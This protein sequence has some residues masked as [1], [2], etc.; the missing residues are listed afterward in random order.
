MVMI[1]DGSVR[2]SGIAAGGLTLISTTTE[3]KDVEE[4]TDVSLPVDPEDDP[5]QDLSP[6]DAVILLAS[7]LAAG[8]LFSF[9]FKLFMSGQ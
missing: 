4:F 6:K 9:G 8:S 7:G 3:L 2:W 1:S 5:V